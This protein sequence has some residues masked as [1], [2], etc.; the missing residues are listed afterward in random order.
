MLKVD[1]DLKDGTKFR[2]SGEQAEKASNVVDCDGLIYFGGVVIT[3]VEN[4]SNYYCR[5]EEEEEEDKKEDKS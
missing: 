3:P 2:L 5:E 1:I 4:L